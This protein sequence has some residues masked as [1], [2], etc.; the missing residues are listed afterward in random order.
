MH[1]A[2]KVVPDR[3]K[4]FFDEKTAKQIKDFEKSLKPPQEPEALNE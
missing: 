4:A 1:H 3:Q 2:K